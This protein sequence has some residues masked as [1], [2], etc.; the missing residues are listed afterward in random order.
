MVQDAAAAEALALVVPAEI[1]LLNSP[2]RPIVLLRKRS[3]S[4]VADEVAPGNPQLGVMLPYTPL[5]HLLVRALDGIPLVM[6]SGNRSDEPIAYEDADA[7]QRLAAIADLFLVH[8]RP[9][10]V[11]CD[12]A[13]TRIVSGTEM[14]IRRSRGYAPEPITLP[15]NCP[16]PLAALG[17]QLKAT[18]ALG[19]QRHA[20]VSHHLG[21]LDHLDAYHAFV[22]DLALY[23]QLFAVKPK[24][25]VHDLHPDYA[26][27]RYAR[28]RSEA[29][30]IPLLAVQ[31][32]HAHMAS[33]MAE[34]GL[35]EQV[36][37]VSF[38]GAGYGSDGAIWGGEFLVGDYQAFRRAG[39]L[40]YV[41]MP[42]GEQA[43]HE[44]WRMALAHLTDAEV[45]DSLL[46]RRIPPASLRTARQMI[47]RR[48][49]TPMTSSTG[50]LF[51]A[52][53]ALANVRDRVTFE[54]QAAV[55]LEWVAGDMADV[56]PYPWDMGMSTEGVVVVDTRPVIRS[57]AD[58][59]TRGEE[60]CSIARRFHATMA[61]MIASVCARIRAS[62]GPSSV[63]LSGGVFLNALL[64]RTAEE[65][66]GRAGF[67]V[68]RHHK[69]PP[70][71][72][73]LSLGQLA[74]AATSLARR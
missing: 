69:V 50:R 37:G 29:E 68:Y 54:G 32:H 72:G 43:I 13:V 49:N 14:P 63:V 51:D 71:D 55:E 24:L 21:D 28:Q 48:F 5:H 31:H 64:T 6:T 42:G 9:I 38:D 16:V 15:M 52:I 67:R 57:V 47:Q 70:N 18:F 25:L 30:G 23:E 61:D 62:S 33:C 41:G 34:H 2:R 3:P 46:A 66:L 27:T 35:T 40:R 8:D 12:D 73:G 11:R 39:H 60:S 44:P 17:G 26:S 74:I 58:D 22:K 36:I 4:T 65:R 20:F 53:A 19:R 45:D 59:M 7:V 56:L 1:G 10:H